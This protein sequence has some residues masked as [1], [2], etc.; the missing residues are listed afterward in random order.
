MK[1]T[2]QMLIGSSE[3]TGTDAT[4][5]ATNPA[6]GETLQ[7]SFGG[8]G[9]REV[10]QACLL[11]KQAAV[12]YRATSLTAR[13]DFLEEIG[14]GLIALGDTLTQRA[15]AE[16]GLTAVRINGERARTV[17]QLQLFAQVVRS[18]AFLDA[19][20]EPALSMR[21]P[22]PRPDLRLQRMPLGPVAVFGASNFPLAFSVAGGD[23]VSALAAG[24]PV[25]V[26][27][28]QAHLG[29]SELVGRVIQ[30]AAHNT[31]M[32]EG[33]FSMLIGDGN[34][35]GEALVA[36]PAIRAVGFTGSR[37]GGLA[38]MHI[39][40]Q[41][42]VP[43]PVYAEM[44]STNPLFVLPAALATRG[45]IIAS[46]F[47]DALIL[48]AGQFCTNPGLVIG[49]EG[50]DL[51]RFMKVASEALNQKPAA[52]MLT[53]P[54]SSAYNAGV[55]T[56]ES[57]ADV[58]L[59]ARSQA[60]TGNN[61]AQAAL[62]YTCADT[63]LKDSI[64][65][66]EVFGPSSVIVGCR[67]IV[68]LNNIAEQIEGQ[69]TATLHIDAADYADARA[70]IPLLEDIAGRIVVNGFPTGVDVGHAMVHG[71]PFPA[72]SDVR[73]TS[74]GAAAIER[75]LRPICYQDMPEALL[76]EALRDDAKTPQAIL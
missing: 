74:V 37:K 68:E 69:L 17:W 51:H 35:I 29:T 12:T 60:P 5:Y 55:T 10:A 49:I 22:I 26:K 7:P 18:G 34:A 50:D 73:T 1:I 3:V 33:V 53:S 54:I 58:K 75:F 40:Q 64:V 30:R 20:I 13:A 42:H 56:L 76:P 72:T 36:H 8:G 48:G 16:T 31:G 57:H 6:S 39:A 21:T 65:Q 28:H 71:G 45:D 4:L 61:Q 43:I 62:F 66:T 52:T 44:S 24:C 25:I 63:F 23:T 38:L 41:R 11:A 14:R 32:P 67:D 27:A 70:L 2:G 59:L 15:T 19:T 9:Q 46:G 47:V